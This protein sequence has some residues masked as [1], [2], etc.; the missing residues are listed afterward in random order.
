MDITIDLKNYTC[1]N[2]IFKRTAARAIIKKGHEYLLIFSKYGDYKFPGG[3]LEKGEE[4]ED[5]LV[6]EVQE[7]TGYHV[8]R[9]SMKKYGKVLERRKGNYE[10]VME[11]DS[12]Y[13][14]CD[15]EQEIGSRNL[16]EYE[17]EYNYQ[18]V[19]IT[20]QEAIEK[21]KQ[22]TDLDTCPWVTRDTMVMEMLIGGSFET[23][24]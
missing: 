19:W 14:F 6:R 7:E 22:V 9:R 11:M 16:D 23:E 8:V 2:S 4:L 21:N 24:K 12:H 13:F 18:I 10:D 1:E 20:L 17:A 15:V 3:G 5:T